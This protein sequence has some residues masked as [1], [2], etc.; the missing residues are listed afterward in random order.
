MFI[1]QARMG[2]KVLAETEAHTSCPCA[3]FITDVISSQAYITLGHSLHGHKATGILSEDHVNND[4]HKHEYTYTTLNTRGSHS[5]WLH[6][7]SAS[8]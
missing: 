4:N 7:P 2:Y 5:V 6:I 3:E 1:P 8:L